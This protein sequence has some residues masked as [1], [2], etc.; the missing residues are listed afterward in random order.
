ML[1]SKKRLIVPRKPIVLRVWTLLFVFA[2]LSHTAAAQDDPAAPPQT[3][4][5]SI[6]TDDYHIGAGDVLQ[7]TVWKEPEVSVPS[8]V[9]RPDGKVAIPL[10]KDVTVEGMTPQV[11]E[12]AIARELGKYVNDP[13]VSVVVTA[14]NSKKVYVIGA[15]TTQGP[16]PYSYRMSV[17]Q[18][19]SEAGG[20]T[21]FA[22]RK[23]IYVL[24]NEGGKEYRLPFDYTA[25][26]KGEKMEQ[27]V[28][29]IPGDTL[30]V[31]Q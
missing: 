11:A 5:A 23:Q 17:M 29:L 28:Q 26:I 9:V 3:P 4:S 10:I 20:L 15:V 2:A 12:A 14:I 8:V 31:P 19:L 25:V 13:N 7:I 30:V 27:N 16:I 18:A 22:K 24:R 21:D 1:A 6:A